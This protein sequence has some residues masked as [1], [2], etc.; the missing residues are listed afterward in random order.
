MSQSIQQVLSAYVPQKQ[1][2]TKIFADAQQ[3][4]LQALF[5]D[6]KGWL[7]VSLMD[8]I[9][10]YNEE[11]VGFISFRLRADYSASLGICVEEVVSDFDHKHQKPLLH[12]QFAKAGNDFF[13]FFASWFDPTDGYSPETITLLMKQAN[14][15]IKANYNDG[16]LITNTEFLFKCFGL[17]PR[18]N[19]KKPIYIEGW[20]FVIKNGTSNKITYKHCF[21]PKEVL[22][23]E[24]DAIDKHLIEEHGFPALE[25]DDTIGLSSSSDFASFFEDLDITDDNENIE[26][27]ESRPGELDMQ[28]IN[29][30]V[31]TQD[32]INCIDG[33]FSEVASAIRFYASALV[34][35]DDDSPSIDEISL[36]AGLLRNEKIRDA[37]ADELGCTSDLLLPTSIVDFQAKVWART[38]KFKY[39]DRARTHGIT[40]IHKHTRTR[41]FFNINQNSTFLMKSVIHQEGNSV[42]LDLT[43]FKELI[44]SIR[45]EGVVRNAENKVVQLPVLTLLIELN[46]SSD[47]RRAQ[48]KKRF[49]EGIG[50]ITGHESTK[51]QMV[52]LFNQMGKSPRGSKPQ[53]L[54]C[55]SHADVESEEVITSF[56]NSINKANNNNYFVNTINMA[57]FN[58]RYSNCAL[59]GT[60]LFYRDANLGLLT[61][62]S[63][64]YS[65]QIIIL[66]NFEKASTSAQ[67]VIIPALK[68]EKIMEKFAEQPI[69][70]SQSI[71]IFSSSIDKCITDGTSLEVE[72]LDLPS[73]LGDGLDSEVMQFLQAGVHLFVDKLTSAEMQQHL[74]M[75]A[76]KLPI[77]NDESIKKSASTS[78]THTAVSPL[79]AIAMLSE[80]LTPSKINSAANK[81]DTEIDGIRFNEAQIADNVKIRFE[82]PRDFY[83]S[84]ANISSDVTHAFSETYQG[85]QWSQKYEYSNT[86][87]DGVLFI[88]VTLL[89]PEI[90]VS[91]EDTQIPFMKILLKTN[92]NIDEVMG[93]ENVKNVI[94]ES[95]HKLK[96]GEVQ[97]NGITLA[98][99]PGSGKTMT[100]KAIANEAGMPIILVNS[101]EIL[102]GN[103]VENLK[104]VFSTA[105]KYGPCVVAFDEIDSIAPIRSESSHA[106]ALVTNSFLT[107]LDGFG[108]DHAKFLVIGSTNNIACIDP[109]LLRNGRLGT[110]INMSHPT[111]TKWLELLPLMAKKYNRHLPASHKSTLAKL[112]SGLSIL[113]IDR[114]INNAN[115]VAK[116]SKV[117]FTEQMYPA[118]LDEHIG[119]PLQKSFCPKALEQTAYHEAGHALVIMKLFG[120][121]SISCV[122]VTPRK[123]SL[124]CVISSSNDTISQITVRN[125]KHNI[126]VCLAGRAAELL[127]YEDREL[128]STGASGDLR[129]ATTL[130]KQAIEQYGFGDLNGLVDQS[131]FTQVNDGLRQECI[132]WLE[133]GDQTATNILKQNWSQVVL[134]ANQLIAKKTLSQ[135]Q[136]TALLKD[137]PSAFLQVA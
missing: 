76:N 110:H 33:S 23:P 87:T 10:N 109:A 25:E 14:D 11:K 121:E 30:N 42:S 108:T 120:S 116:S 34:D 41:S 126:A 50:S 97:K 92:V 114:A 58:D 80:G 65:K 12:R 134:L 71:I 103:P 38:D 26:D 102:V 40:F 5:T 72:N 68:G 91:K 8:I 37:F 95:C 98:G 82:V 16:D 29:Q 135:H 74:N 75:V 18:L 77:D 96:L 57:T 1:K 136:I 54:T 63:I 115:R 85:V 125:I 66:K 104:R 124:G 28:S 132:K 4:T 6:P 84:L 45:D 129:K 128:L 15:Y 51:N 53:V 100:M 137:E 89:R 3:T 22:N 48:S 101:P 119:K 61:G 105:Q 13:N 19:T 94:L 106:T 7:V 36:L 32:C 111:A 27:N 123:G 99:E 55:L 70:L 21:D 56:V 62:P 2:Q 81:L 118:L 59:L 47:K 122:D 17:L 73:L 112:A 88:N 83:N 39:E 133:V 64:P 44:T 131:Q 46:S 78:T 79:L 20:S 35:S 24:S 130:A 90:R 117:S 127:R 60:D 43:M 86:L 113:S 69:D 93:H 9:T 31:N 107:C 67:S 49:I 52:Q